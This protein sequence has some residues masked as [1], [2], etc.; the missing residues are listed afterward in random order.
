MGFGRASL[1]APNELNN[2]LAEADDDSYNP[3]NINTLSGD[4]NGI[5][6]GQFKGL[7]DIPR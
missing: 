2:F 5:I 6:L 7:S 3:V 4:M 1:N